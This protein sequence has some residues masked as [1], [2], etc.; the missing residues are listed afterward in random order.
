MGEGAARRYIQEAKALGEKVVYGPPS[1]MSKLGHPSVES[2]DDD[3]AT[4]VLPL[5]TA[6]AERADALAAVLTKVPRPKK[7]ECKVPKH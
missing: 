6:P 7:S 3:M 5:S 4:E 2:H 1:K